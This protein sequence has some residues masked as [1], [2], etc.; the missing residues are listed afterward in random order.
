M[1]EKVF[2]DCPGCIF[3]EVCFESGTCQKKAIEAKFN[4][5]TEIK[6]DD[7][8]PKDLSELT[9]KADYFVF[10]DE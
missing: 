6:E 5:D 10:I 2:A 8:L 7:G 4:L 9:D 3:P 1:V